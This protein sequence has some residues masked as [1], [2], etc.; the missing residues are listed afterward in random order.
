MT[1]PNLNP[2]E[3]DFL[4]VKAEVEK[5][6]T[7]YKESPRSSSFN[8]LVL[9]ESGTGKSFLLHTARK[10]IHLDCFDPGNTKNLVDLI[11]KGEL[12]PDIRWEEENPLTPTVFRDWEKVMKERIRSGY[13]DHFGTYCLDS[14]TTWTDAI[15]NQI[16]KSEG[17]AGQP[18]R[19]AHDYVPQKVK[20]QN[21][22]KILM[23]LPCD[24]ILTGHLEGNK[25]DVTGRMSYRYMVTG[26][27]QVTI[28][29]L[30]DEIYIM[31]PKTT[32][33]GV[34]YRILTQSNGTYLA[35]SRMAKKGLLTTYEKPDIKQMLQKCGFPTEDKP[36]FKTEN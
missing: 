25:D 7:M 32:S 10:P 17:I 19:W 36:L 4:K 18:P 1:E 33:S 12:I 3:N 28:P 29:L 35:R 27:A 22:I 26:K 8:I 21:W 13:F 6:Q 20:I 31:E 34:E 24:F 14:S 9:G 11:K 30:F 2:N 16:L 5:L 23:K 15:M